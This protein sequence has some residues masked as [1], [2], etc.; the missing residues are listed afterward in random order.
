[1]CVRPPC[2]NCGEL[3]D[4]CF[5]AC[6]KCGHPNGDGKGALLYIDNVFLS[7]KEVREKHYCK[8][9]KCDHEVVRFET[10]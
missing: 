8:I 9:C 4:A 1:M 2:E 10:K 7:V 5:P 3:Y 6:P